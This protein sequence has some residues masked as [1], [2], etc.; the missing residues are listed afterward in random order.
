MEPHPVKTVAKGLKRYWKEIVI[1]SLRVQVEGTDNKQH[2]L[3]KCGK[4][5]K[6]QYVQLK[7]ANKF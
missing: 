6:Q 3:K 5:L 4:L 1:S 7:F 2:S